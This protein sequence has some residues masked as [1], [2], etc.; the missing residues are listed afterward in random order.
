MFM[1]ASRMNESRNLQSAGKHELDLLSHSKKN[2][3]IM[4]PST[5]LSFSQSASDLEVEVKRR[6]EVR[7]PP[8]GHH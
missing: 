3:G 5:Y 2:L 1:V 4:C 6:A 7:R 8:T